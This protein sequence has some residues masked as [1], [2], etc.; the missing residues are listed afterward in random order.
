MNV[1]SVSLPVNR[2]NRP[3]GEAFCGLK[4][5]EDLEAALKLHKQNLSNRYIE[6]IDFHSYFEKCLDLFNSMCLIT[7]VS[8]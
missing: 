5:K 1:L 6:G 8:E 2:E 7:S 3:S 4:R